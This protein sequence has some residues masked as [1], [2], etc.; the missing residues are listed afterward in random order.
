MIHKVKSGG[1][2]GGGGAGGGSGNSGEESYQLRR[3]W[4]LLDLP[5]VDG[6]SVV[7]PEFVLHTAEKPLKW[8]ATSATEKANF[9][10]SLLKVFVFCGV[11]LSAV[12]SLPM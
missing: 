5:L 1:G 2:G 9:L 7:S 3:S 6:L 11:M 4:N 12:P 8:M 10:Q